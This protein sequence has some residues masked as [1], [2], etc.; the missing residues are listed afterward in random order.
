[1]SNGY[2]IT[3]SGFITVFVNGE[4][5]NVPSDHLNYEKIKEKLLRKE[6]DGLEGLI[7][8]D[9]AIEKKF[10]D[11]IVIKNDNLLYNSRVLNNTLSKKVLEFV[12]N[13]YDC[14]HLIKFLQKLMK[15]PS[16]RS[17]EQ[18]YEFLERHHF[19]IN[20]D[21]DFL[22]YKGVN[23]QLKDCHTGTV[24]N[25]PGVTNV[26]ERNLISD[27]PDKACHFGFHV[28]SLRYA[29]SF[30]QRLLLVSVSPEDVV[31]VPYDSSYEK[32]RV[33]KYQVL[34]ELNK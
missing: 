15:N 27:D 16:A 19:I 10:G 11:S 3:H 31:C 34:K 1:M 28:G 22:A 29:S 26:M 2:V 33:C 25:S 4:I 30:G 32:I 20:E 21:G 5:F 12:R 8:V 7:K 9:K 13:N 18:L 24:D 17:V 23:N 14:S 6:Y